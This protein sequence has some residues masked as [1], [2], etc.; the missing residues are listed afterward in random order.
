M[1]LDRKSQA[2]AEDC[3][4]YAVP[5]SQQVISR[6]LKINAAHCS[7][8]VRIYLEGKVKRFNDRVLAGNWQDSW[9]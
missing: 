1:R 8:S 6:V 9:Q 2:I 7:D 4:G 3:H 5:V